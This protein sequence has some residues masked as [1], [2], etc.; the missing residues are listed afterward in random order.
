MTS[1]WY[2]PL[3]LLGYGF[4]NKNWDNKKTK[5]WKNGDINNN[6]NNDNNGLITISNEG[7]NE[8]LIRHIN[9]T[10]VKLI[11]VFMSC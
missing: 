5:N 4:Y 7:W 2:L 8:G 10:R 9:A 3:L 11:I 1:L 6:D